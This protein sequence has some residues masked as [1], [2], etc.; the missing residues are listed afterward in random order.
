MKGADRSRARRTGGAALAL[1]CASTVAALVLA[2][3]Y[4]LGVPATLVAVLGG[5]PGLYLAWAGYRDAQRDSDR[6]AAL[7]EIADELAVRDRSQ[8]ADEA[9]ARG[10]NDPYPLPVA[11]SAADASLAGDLDLLKRLA[12]S[13]AGWSA[14]A[15][16]NWATSLEDLAS[17]GVRRL[18]DVLAMVPAGRR[19]Q[20]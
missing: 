18:V 17:G 1:V 20:A 6:T 13:G 19:T 5:F 10:L 3:D 9:E 7:A 8:W 16:E 2:H 4:H 15:R 14:R 12:T 11:W